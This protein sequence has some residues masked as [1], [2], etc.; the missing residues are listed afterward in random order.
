VQTG[1]GMLPDAQAQPYLDRAHAQWQENRFFHWELE[2]PV[3]FFDQYGRGKPNPGFDA[4][5]GNPPYGSILD[6]DT[7]DWARQQYQSSGTTLDTFAMFLERA[8]QLATVRGAIGEIVPS[9][10]LTAREHL[11]LRSVLLSQ[12][13]PKTIVHMPYDVFPD[14]YIDTIVWVGEKSET[15]RLSEPLEVLVKRFGHREKV[16]RMPQQLKDYQVING[17]EWLLDPQML[18]VTDTGPGQWLGRWV[19]LSHFVPADEL[20]SVS[21]GITPFVEPKPGETRGTALGFF[22]SVGRYALE[23]KKFASVVYDPSLMEY[24]PIEFFTGP[25][26]II[27]RI[28]S[29]QHRIHAT[30]VRENFVINKSYLPAIATTDEYALAYVLAILN[31]KLLSRSF[32]ARSE[33]AKRDDFPQLDI[34]TVREFPIRRIAFTTLTEERERLTGE[35][36]G[37]CAE[38]FESRSTGRT[39]GTEGISVSSAAFHAF[40]DS[41]LSR[42]LDARLTADGSSDTEHEQSDVVHDLLAHLSEQMIEMNKEKQAETRGFL[43]WLAE[44][45]GLP[46]EDWTL[47]TSLKAYYQHDW[48]EMRRVLDRNRRKITKV[49]VK[50]REASD[51]IQGEWEASLEKLRPLLARIAATD[52]LIDLIVCRLYGLT[53]EEVGVVEGR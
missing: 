44:Y 41:N 50:G 30:L 32:V 5:M 1:K 24:K 43:G 53:E 25:R 19:R 11:P 37:L 47:K 33:I 46:V 8:A 7:K 23:L 15:G 4:V 17:S 48:A 14:A 22:G 52:R 3:V 12:T 9:G 38:W 28:I 21:R 26:L 27:R 49:N 18:I 34:A 13:S 16:E 6:D 51:L 45:T 36:K 31:S 35:G 42:W 2:F 29:R 10:W 39:E 40:R 20:I